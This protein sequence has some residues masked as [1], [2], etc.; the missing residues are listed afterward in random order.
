MISRVLQVEN[1]TFWPEKSR[2]W[3]PNWTPNDGLK[4]S[5]IEGHF[6]RIASIKKCLW[7]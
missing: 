6:Q 2:N 5:E 3:T 7:K 4:M 1:V